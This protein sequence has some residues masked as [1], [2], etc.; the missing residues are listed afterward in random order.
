MTCTCILPFPVQAPS[1]NG[2]CTATPP[3]QY[4]LNYPGYLDYPPTFD[5]IQYRMP[6]ATFNATLADGYPRAWHVWFPRGYVQSNNTGVFTTDAANRGKFNVWYALHGFT[7]NAFYPYYDGEREWPWYAHLV[8]SD[9]IH[10][11]QQLHTRGTR[12]V[13]RHVAHVSSCMCADEWVRSC[14]RPCGGCVAP[15]VCTRA[16]RVTCLMP[17][18]PLLQRVSSTR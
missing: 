15:F 17:C 2:L 4:Y 6:G 13:E 3:E 14:V 9:S 5:A 8:E 11:L 7:D 16:P 18:F 12:S 10:I 1:L